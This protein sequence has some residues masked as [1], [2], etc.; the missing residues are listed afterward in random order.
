MAIQVSVYSRKIVLQTMGFG[1]FVV[2]TQIVTLGDII[3]S[4]N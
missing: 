2:K 1:E 3:M 4:Q